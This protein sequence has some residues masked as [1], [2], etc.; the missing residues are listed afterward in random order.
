MNMANEKLKVLVRK[1]REEK[2]KEGAG[3]LHLACN[4]RKITDFC[5]E[6]DSDNSIICF[7]DEPQ[8][9]RCHHICYTGSPSQFRIKNLRWPSEGK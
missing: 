2:K 5:V 4:G 9:V 6:A 1:E 8:G 7:N 3:I